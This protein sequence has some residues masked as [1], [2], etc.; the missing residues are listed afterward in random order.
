MLVGDDDDDDDGDHD[1]D[2]DD[3]DDD[4]DLWGKV[5]YYRGKRKTIT[6]KKI[7]PL[8]QSRVSYIYIYI[9]SN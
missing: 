2:D 8:E 4:D 5:N 6:R 9:C 1:E 7:P 3:D